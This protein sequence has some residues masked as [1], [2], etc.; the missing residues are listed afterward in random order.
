MS[1]LFEAST[2]LAQLSVLSTKGFQF[3]GMMLPGLDPRVNL[4]RNREYR[5]FMRNARCAAYWQT[6]L[7]FPALHGSHAFT[8]VVGYVFPATQYVCHASH[9]RTVALSREPTFARAVQY[10]EMRC[11]RVRNATASNS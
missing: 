6:H 10:R 8:Q 4:S 7:V 9:L 11:A 2:S 1:P 3:T 5:R